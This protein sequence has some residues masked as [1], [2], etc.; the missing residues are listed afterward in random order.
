MSNP[1]DYTYVAAQAFLDEKHKGPES[2]STNDNNDYTLGKIGKHNV[3]I[4]ILP[5]G[6]YGISSA[7]SVARDMLHSFPNIRIGLMVGI[8]GGAPSHKHDIRLGDVVVSASGNGKGGEFQETGF[9]NQPP[10]ILRAAVNGLMAQYEGEGIQLEESISK[11]LKKKPRLQKKYRRPKRSTDRLYQPGVLHP[12]NDESSYAI[13]CDNDPS[14]LI[15]RPKRTEGEDNP[16]IHYGLIASSNRLMKDALI[17][18]ALIRKKDVLCFEM[19]AAGLMNHFPC[20]VIR[21]V[22]DYLDLHKNK[23]WQGYAAI[24]SASYAKDLLCCIPPNRIKAE[25]KISEV[26]SV[27]YEGIHCL[28][29]K[30]HNQEYKSILKTSSKTMFY[31]GDL[32]IGIAYVYCNFQRHDQQRINDLLASLLK[33]LTQGQPSLP[34]GVKTLH[35]KHKDNRAPPSSEEISMTLRS[36]T[37]IYQR[38]SNSCRNDFLLEL[39]NLQA[40]YGINLFTTS[41]P[42]PEITKQIKAGISE[43]VDGMFLLAQIYLKSFDDKLI[44][45][46]QKKAS[47]GNMDWVLVKAYDIAMERINGQKPGLREPLIITELQHA[48]AIKRNKRVLDPGDLPQIGDM[49]SQYFDE[50]RTLFLNAEADITTTCITYLSFDIFK[51][52]FYQTDKEF[53]ERI[54]LNPFYDY[55]AH[56]WVGIDAKDWFHRTPLSWAAGEGREAIVKL[57]LATGKV[58]INAKDRSG[59]TPLWWAAEGGHEA[60]VKLLLEHGADADLKDK[61]GLTALSWATTEGNVAIVQLLAAQRRPMP[62][63]L[64]TILTLII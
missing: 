2:I 61:D 7:A 64:N 4:A 54:R 28:V 37:T 31:P 13:A 8:G 5:H 36:V 34:E 6:E 48:L 33:Q 41:R 21:G 20:L 22:C 39:F 45:N 63:P 29:R 58:D 51:S 19:E 9:L 17:Q 27:I 32:R 23:G 35:D 42:L 62:E 30:Q 3:V 55:S 52:G 15:V 26:L 47:G 46:A 40:R 50:N 12:P 59:R 60:I 18:D 14:T 1:H 16:S 10:T 49:V 43:A 24:I 53:E 57:L 38:A 56:H 44:I 25:K 11:V